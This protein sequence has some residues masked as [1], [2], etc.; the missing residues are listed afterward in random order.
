[1]DIQDNKMA[2]H[3]LLLFIKQEF[4]IRAAIDDREISILEMQCIEVYQSPEAFF[5]STGWARDNPEI[6]D[7]NY[8]LDN[9]ICWLV[10]GQ[11]WYFSRIRFEEGLRKL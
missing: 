5:K 10:E 9:K 6:A 8:L 3:G 4:F 1:M 11:V 2:V 7:F